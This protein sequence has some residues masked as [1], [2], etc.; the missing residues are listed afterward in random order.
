MDD[1]KSA[2]AERNKPPTLPPVKR[3]LRSASA[4]VTPA[5]PA[6]TAA[7]VE[8][9]QTSKETL[10]KATRAML[11]KEGFLKQVEKDRGFQNPQ[12]IGEGYRGVGVRVHILLPPTNPYPW[13]GYRG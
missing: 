1:K 10:M 6:A 8:Q 2:K 12:G 7:P 5:M 11:D 9:N 13:W 4:A 3:A